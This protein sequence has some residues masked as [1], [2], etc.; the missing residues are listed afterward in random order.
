MSKLSSAAILWAYL[1]N[2]E[3]LYL[4]VAEYLR[5][6]FQ[7]PKWQN[8][9]KIEQL[10]EIVHLSEKMQGKLAIPLLYQVVKSI[11]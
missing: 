6:V 4:N 10:S 2:L 8:F 9:R 11:S 5:Y 7:I 1:F 3:D